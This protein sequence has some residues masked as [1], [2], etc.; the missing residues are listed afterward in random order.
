MFSEHGGTS[1][2]MTKAADASTAMFLAGAPETR[3]GD[4]TKVVDA[5]STAMAAKIAGVKK[6]TLENWVQRGILSPSITSHS[7]HR[8]QPRQYTF[9]DL[10]AIRVLVVLRDAGID[11]G[12]L[13][14]VVD[15]LTKRTSLS[16][17]DAL[18]STL[19]ITDGH[20]VYEVEDNVPISA[21]RKPGQAILHVIPLGA[22]VSELGQAA[23]K[24][25]EAA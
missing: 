12:G 20:D 24:F 1:V 5:F 14:R 4:T 11:L 23:R 21:Y 10:V 6:T 7:T 2:I 25:T 22:L 3:A 15:Y 13:H 18:A 8:T 19:L 9:R 17:T 16:A